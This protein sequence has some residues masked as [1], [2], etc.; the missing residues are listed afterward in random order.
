MRTHPVCRYI[1][2]VAHGH[3]THPGMVQSSQHELPC[4]S[5][6][7]WMPALN[8]FR[9][10]RRAKGAQSSAAGAGAP[11]T[12]RSSPYPDSVRSSPYPGAVRS[13]P[14]PDSVRSSPLPEPSSSSHKLSAAAVPVP[15]AAANGGSEAF[16]TFD[17]R[18]YDDDDQ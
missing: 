4:G 14:Y 12:L 1:A 6:V 17:N 2:D 18:L 5:L 3:C 9:E 7:K 15:I 13:S 11:A 10:R 8:V 16:T